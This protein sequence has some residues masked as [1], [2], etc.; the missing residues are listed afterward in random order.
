MSFFSGGG[1]TFTVSEEFAIL[2]MDANLEEVVFMS[3]EGDQ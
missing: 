2:E 3:M 1:L